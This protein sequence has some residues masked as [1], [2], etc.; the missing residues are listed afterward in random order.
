MSGRARGARG[1]AAGLLVWAINVALIQTVG[2]FGVSMV[3]MGAVLVFVGSILLIWGDSFRTMPVAQ[4]I[5]AALIAL[6]PVAGA[7]IA[8]L[9]WSR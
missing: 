3:L 4:K 7:V 8:L 9:R 1:L 6:A 2:V 5:P